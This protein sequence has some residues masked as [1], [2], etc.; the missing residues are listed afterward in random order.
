MGCAVETP[1]ITINSPTEITNTFV[2]EQDSLGNCEGSITADPIGGTR[3]YTI[4]WSILPDTTLEINDLCAGTYI[5]TITDSNGCQLIDTATVNV[6]VNLNEHDQNKAYIYPNPAA[7]NVTIV[8]QSHFLGLAELYDNF[9]RL[10]LAESLING[11]ARLDIDH[12][13]AGSYIIVIKLDG[14]DPVIKQLMIE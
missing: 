13:A 11:R 12:F 6:L 8:A 4:S 7:Q 5:I 14:K 1:I 10:I 9:G 2:I 3:P